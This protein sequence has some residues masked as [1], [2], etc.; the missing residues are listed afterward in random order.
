MG[1]DTNMERTEP[2]SAPTY[3]VVP[4]SVNRRKHRAVSKKL[5]CISVQW[6]PL[7]IGFLLA[8]TLLLESL[9]PF[10]VAYIAASRQQS[11]EISIWSF[12][13]VMIGLA[14][15]MSSGI[16]VLPYYLISVII[17]FIGFGGKAYTDKLWIISIILGFFLIKIPLGLLYQPMAITWIITIAEI[18]LAVIGYGVLRSILARDRSHNLAHLEL[19]LSLLLVGVLMGVDLVIAGFSI[20]MLIMFYLMQ[21]AVRL[22]DFYLASM[23]GP[24]LLVICL[25][26]QLPIEIGVIL[27][28]VG[29]SGGLLHKLPGGLWIG[30]FLACLLVCG[31]PVQGST[32]NLIATLSIANT[33]VFLTPAHYQRQLE[34]I[35]PG[36]D[37]YT[38]REANRGKRMQA[39]LE[40]RIEQFSQIF[41]EL[42]ATLEDCSFLSQQ[43]EEFSRIIKDLGTE[44]ESP[45][46]F[47]E[48]IEEKLLQRIDCLDLK[49]L[50]VTRGLDGCEV[51]GGRQTVC[52]EGWCQ[53]VAKACAHLLGNPYQVME[54]GCLHNGECRFVIR[55]KVRYRL[56]IKSAKVAQGAISGDSNSV[57]ALAAGK[58]GLLLS[59]GMGIGERAAAESLATIRLLEKMILMGYERELAV[60]IINQT[61]LARNREESFVTIDLVVSDLQTGQLEFVK[62][63]GAPS[64]IKRGC[65][66]DV[67]WNHSLPVGILQHVDVEPERRL[68]KEGDFLIMVTD[69]VL[70]A[71]RT[72]THKDEWMCNLLR[73]LDDDMSCEELANSILA[74][75]LDITDGQVQDDAM[76]LVAKLIREDREIYAYRGN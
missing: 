36:T 8:R 67:I 63:G 62:I 38:E 11:Q 52:G 53:D 44:L 32:V 16:A 55:P 7:I 69:G 17:W 2:V 10:G 27:V 60:K 3:R 73:R 33:L 50:T 15:L 22:G 65:E 19:H 74:N 1:D 54:R 61:L 40:N 34:R 68:L 42:A 57:F 64:F 24:V 72:T 75:S 13:G 46:Q 47:V 71:Q 56:E 18:G 59:D 51:F 30:G 29:V 39:Q 12:I 31:L 25:L 76:V 21:L 14:S 20:R 6:F 48:V 43:L 4:L 5:S 49:N 26:L 23:I 58:M 35:I 41:A 37:R 28:L 9:L 66:V 45:E 70:E